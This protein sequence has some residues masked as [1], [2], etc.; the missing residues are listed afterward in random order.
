MTKHSWTTDHLQSLDSLLNRLT[1]L[2]VFCVGRIVPL[3][4][5]QPFQH[6]KLSMAPLMHPKP[7]PDELF[8]ALRKHYSTIKDIQLDFWKMTLEQSKIFLEGCLT[9]QYVRLMIDA[10]FGKLVGT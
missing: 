4:A 10:P 7:L 9:L 3:E 6:D 8:A 2:E 5:E 1:R